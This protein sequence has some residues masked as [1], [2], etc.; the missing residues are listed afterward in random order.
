MAKVDGLFHEQDPIEFMIGAA[1]F[2]SIQGGPGFL[3]FFFETQGDF[4]R[5]IR[6]EGTNLSVSNLVYS[7]TVT[8]VTVFEAEAISPDTA[9]HSFTGK[10][11]FA[12]LALHNL[13]REKIIAN[14]LAGDDTFLATDSDDDIFSRAGNDRLLGGLGEDYFD[15]GRGNDKMTGGEDVDTFFFRRGS[16][17]DVI[18]DFDAKGGEG[19]QDFI[20]LVA[21]TKF[22]V[23]RNGRDTVIDLGRG[24]T[25]TLLDVKA[26]QVTEAD[27]VFAV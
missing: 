11:K 8:K 2:Y 12:D 26:S 20:E 10:W 4:N 19:N 6:F 9:L 18:T 1:G 23:E 17:K 25:L 3:E 14:L 22:D 5:S 16:G 24:S 21:G 27:F 15:G 7:G 13:T